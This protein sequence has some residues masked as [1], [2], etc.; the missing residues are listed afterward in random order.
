M[1]HIE[2][3]SQEFRTRLQENALLI[4]PWG[5]KGAFA[6]DN[7]NIYKRLVSPKLRPKIRKLSSNLTKIF[8]P[9]FPPKKVI[10][11]LGAGDSFVGSTIHMLNKEESLERKQFI[12]LGHR[13]L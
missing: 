9:P 3:Q 1:D 5:E 13:N 4:C 6:S 2:N 10:D 8:S 11:T 7:A 12:F